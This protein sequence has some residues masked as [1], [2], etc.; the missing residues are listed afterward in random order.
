[1]T[2]LTEKEILIISLNNQIKNNTKIWIEINNF[3]TQIN[4]QNKGLINRLPMEWER[5]RVSWILGSL[6]NNRQIFPGIDKTNTNAI[7][8]LCLKH[9]EKSIVR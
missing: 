6:N 5:D 3:E 4:N 8:K 9:P 2:R 1:M 7:L